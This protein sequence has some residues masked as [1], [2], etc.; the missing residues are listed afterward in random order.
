MRSNP[1]NRLSVRL[2]LT[3]F[4]VIALAVTALVVTSFLVVRTVWEIGPLAP[5]GVSLRDFVVSRLFEAGLPA[6]LALPHKPLVMLARTL[7]W[8]AGAGGLIGVVAGVT[9]SRRMTAPL[10]ELAAAARAIGARDLSRRVALQ[11]TEEI[12]EVAGAFNQMAQELELAESQRQQLLADIA[13]ELRTP[14]TVI[15]GNLR[16]ILDDVYPLDK[17]EV[18]RLYDQTR[19]LTRLVND[20][21]ELAQADAHQLA[22]N[23]KLVD[24]NDVVSD[25][26]ERFEPLAESAGIRLETLAGADLPPIMVDPMRMLQVLDNLLA[27]ALRHT[28]AGGVIQMET[29][30]AG[31]ALV[32]E[33]VD[34]GEGID[35]ADLPHL[36]DRFYRTD[37]SRNRDTGGSG[38]GL[39]IV[40]SLV[41][42]Q[43]GSVVAYS[44]GLGQGSTF[45][46]WFP[47]VSEG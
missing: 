6:E 44:A 34:S 39:A 1:L 31:D 35:A 20:L 47:L 11:G 42:V 22:L 21:R 13:H 45:R 27:N 38:L 4:A 33:L 18:A 32:V 36:F 30:R 25:A 37:R 17:E 3:F 28:P 2:S 46:V 43:G 40:R 12:V 24:I 16:A 19:Q 10:R 14:I 5:N 26:V 15:Q 23:P 41:E 7:L 8:I 29:R 9:L